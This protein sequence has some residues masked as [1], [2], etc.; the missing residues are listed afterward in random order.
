VVTAEVIKIDS[1]ALLRAAGPGPVRRRLE[2]LVNADVVGLAGAQKIYREA[3]GY[4]LIAEK[5]E[6]PFR[7]HWFDWNKKRVKT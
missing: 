6:K 2:T 5:V 3:F 4:E 7:P 1:L